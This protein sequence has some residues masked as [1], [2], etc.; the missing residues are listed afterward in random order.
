MKWFK[1]FLE[2]KKREE[3][4]MQYGNLLNFLLLHKI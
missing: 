3:Q 2:S 1:P 4:E